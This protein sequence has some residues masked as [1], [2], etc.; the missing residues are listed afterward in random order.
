[1]TKKVA[2]RKGFTLIELLVVVAIIALLIAILLPSLVQAREQARITLC[3]AN[4]R[5]VSQGAA[6]YMTESNDTI[7]FAFPFNYA[8]EGQIW[9]GGLT[10]IIT[11]FIWGGGVPDKATAD[12]NS[13]PG[14]SAG[15]NP[16]QRADTYNIRPIHRPLNKYLSPEV[17]WDDPERVFNNPARTGRPMQLPGFFKCPSDRTA[18]VP[19]AN[20][21][22]TDVEGDT[23]WSTWEFWGTSYATNWYWPYYYWDQKNSK[24]TSKGKSPPYSQN[25]GNIV[26]GSAGGSPFPSLAR[27]MMKDKGGRW[28][29]EFILFYENRLNY[30]MDGARPRG[31]AN[32]DAK[33]FK[34]W[35]NRLDYHAAGFLD[36]HA[37]YRRF[38]TRYVDGPGW[39]TWPNRPWV[40]DWAPYNLE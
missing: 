7:V 21:T 14:T 34:G 17:S 16:V 19:L 27:D 32:N 18:A 24:G 37:T 36:G 39:T 1:M 22:N 2:S 23:P 29:T 28:A 9:P 4:L 30:A 10:K 3:I 12:W 6:G 26:A 20:G 31:L 35:H 5:S 40:D 11:E 25:Y 13:G 38:D 15:P 8:I 33:T